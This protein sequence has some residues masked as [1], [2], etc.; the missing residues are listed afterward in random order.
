MAL[1]TK[2]T[3]PT[4]QQCVINVRA[5]EFVCMCVVS[6]WCVCSVSGVCVCVSG[7]YKCMVCMCSASGMHV[8][9]WWCGVVLVCV[10]GSVC[11]LSVCCLSVLWYV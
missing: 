6:V 7:V 1:A 2:R 11:C 5:F 10:R 4:G 8:V 9:M 3:S